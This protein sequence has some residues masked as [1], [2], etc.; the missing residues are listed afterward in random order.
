MSNSQNQ[1]LNPA[2][3]KMKAA[4]DREN[5]YPQQQKIKLKIVIISI[6]YVG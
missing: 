5:G 3:Q 4:L 2:N 1:L 6:A